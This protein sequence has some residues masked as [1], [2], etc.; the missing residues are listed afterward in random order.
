MSI[1]DVDFEWYTKRLD[2][3]TKLKPFESEDDELNDFLLND[4]KNYLTQKLAA[5]AD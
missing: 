2:I 1:K 5:G 4:A 3:D